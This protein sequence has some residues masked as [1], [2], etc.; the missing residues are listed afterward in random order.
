MTERAELGQG[1]GLHG[2]HDD[3]VKRTLLL[4]CVSPFASGN[5]LL[6]HFPYGIWMHWIKWAF[7]P[8]RKIVMVS[9]NI[10]YQC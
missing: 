3:A 5:G 7:I 4:R 6:E 10:S 1:S 2:P 9:P 8:V